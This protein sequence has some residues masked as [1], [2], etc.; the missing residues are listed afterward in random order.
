MI[1]IIPAIDIIGGKCVRLSQGDYDRVKVYD[2]SPVDMAKQFADCGVSRIHLV[3]LD[4]AKASKPVNI[5]T[6]EQIA[7]SVDLELEWGGGLSNDQ[8]LRDIFNAGAACGIIGSAAVLSPEKF[9]GWLKEF[10]GQR[11]ILGADVRGHKVAV[12]GW[13]EDSEQTIE[14][15]IERFL[16]EGLS[17]VICTDISRDG[18][19]SGPNI[20][21]YRQLQE[22][23]PGVEF[24][25]SGGVAGP[26]DIEALA[27]AGM[28]K[29]ITGKAI[30]ENRITLRQIRE[31]AAL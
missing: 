26:Q 29:V 3:D 28:R 20:G 5:R 18:M 15:V 16:P 31:W 9:S 2:A 1:Q 10:S 19:L 23:F 8:A 14:Q 13:T 12:K 30:Y 24:T 7:N 22:T 4:G 27:Q 17:Q 6:L 11:M 25:V 21:L